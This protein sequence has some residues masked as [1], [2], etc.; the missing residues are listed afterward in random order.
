MATYRSTAD[1]HFARLAHIL[2]RKAAYD[3][4][5]LSREFK[6]ATID[7]CAR[8]ISRNGQVRRRRPAAVALVKSF[9]IWSSARNTTVRGRRSCLICLLRT[10]RVGKCSSSSCTVERLGQTTGLCPS[11]TRQFVNVP[12]KFSTLLFKCI[13]RSFGPLLLAYFLVQ[14][15]RCS[16]R[17]P[18]LSL[19][20]V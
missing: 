17:I 15:V 4:C 5:T 19:G 20:L 14:M 2:V 3:C 9:K 8:S 7:G 11:H 18:L 1:T 6:T 13:C 10:S 16:S 12:A